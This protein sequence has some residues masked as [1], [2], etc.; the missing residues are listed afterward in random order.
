MFDAETLDQLQLMF[1]LVCL[2]ILLVWGRWRYDVV[3]LG[4]L[5]TAALFGLVPQSQLF[6]GFGN[7]ATITVVLVLIVSFGLSRSG[8][9]EF[10]TSAIEPLSSRPSLHIAVLSFIAAFLSMFMNNVGALALL[11]PIAI[12]STNKAGR[13]PAS[14]LMPLSFGSIL[15]GLVTLI[16]TPPNI[17]IANYREEVTGQAFTMFDFAPVGGGVALAGIVFML[18]FGSKLVKVRKQAA[19]SEGF[20]IERYL[21]EAKV[22]EDSDFVGQPVGELKNALEAQKMDLVTLQSKRQVSP[23]V[24]RR[25]LLR[26]GDILVL[27]GSQEDIDGFTTEHKFALVSAENSTRELLHS[28]DSQMLEIVVTPRSP[29]VGRTPAESR[30]NRRYGVNLLAASRSGTPHRSRL[31]DFVIRV[32]DVLL[33]HG[34]EDAL[35]D[36]ITKLACYPLAT[37]SL[38]LKRGENSL[39]ALIIFVA[40]IASTAVGLLSIQLALGLACVAMVLRSIVP[41]RELY[42]GVD[43]PVVVLLGAL[44]PLGSALETTGATQVLVGGILNVAGDYSP[45]LLLTL[46]LV[47]TMTV[48]DVLNNAAT[49]ILMA[50]IAYSIATTLGLNPDTFLMAVAIGASCAFLTPIGHQNNALIMGPGGYEFGDYW[51][52]GLPLEVVIVAVAIPL[53]LLA[54]PLAG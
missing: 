28:A 23:V 16:G 3:A 1:V 35:Q 33:L 6:A 8:A 47:V 32:G 34:D 39:P 7:P 21:F 14:V 2:L 54:W 18:V 26:S 27:Q 22:G 36:A 50:P 5:F 11:M 19:G 9:V 29:L 43:W 25:Q 37:R 12:Q 31:R 49:A 30:F 52:V 51:R 41:V 24:N 44:I 20:D 46:I 38:D 45:V 53:L 48:S 42:D 17:L 40:A 15:G 10:V 13:S 4:A